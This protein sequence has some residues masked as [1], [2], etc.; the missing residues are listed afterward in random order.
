MKVKRVTSCV[1]QTLHLKGPYQI[2]RQITGPGGL[3]PSLLVFEAYPRIPTL[4]PPT[5]TTAQRVRAIQKAMAEVE[6]IYVLQQAK[7]A[8]EQRKGLN[9]FCLYDT[10]VGS[11]LMA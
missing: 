2:C 4:D 11:D 6:I 10:L 1:W 7:N 3:V 5:A 8:L 9:A